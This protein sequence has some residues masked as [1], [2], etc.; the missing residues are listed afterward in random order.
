[1]LDLWHYR[2]TETPDSARLRFALSLLNDAEQRRYAAF[3]FDRHRIEYAMAHA[4][5]RLALSR[6]APVPPRNWEFSLGQWGKPS[7]AAPA[8]A[9]PLSFNLSHTNCFVAF[10]AGNK[11]EVGVDIEHLE[12]GGSLIDIARHAFAP[13]E[14]AY[15]TSLTPDRQRDAFFRIWTLKEAYIKATGQGLSLGLDTFSFHFNEG[16]KP[17]LSGGVGDWS[18]FE[19]Q[20]HADYRIAIASRP[21]TQ[22]TNCRDAA[23]LFENE[24]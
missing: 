4:V 8:T 7:I 24:N 19:F 13:S 23:I 2:I 16:D 11:P 20:P 6:Y 12:R 18:F 10:L 5:T 14:H 15:L 22:I 3:Y 9:T 21:G 1:M 17:V